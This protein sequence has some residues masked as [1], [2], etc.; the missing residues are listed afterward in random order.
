MDGRGNTNH[1]QV[2]SDAVLRKIGRNVVLFQQIEGLLKFLV[3]NHKVDG[4]T[5]TLEERRQHR[6]EKAH[7]QT[8]CFSFQTTRPPGSVCSPVKRKY[9]T[10]EETSRH[11]RFSY[12]R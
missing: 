6:V 9:R 2:S 11:P 3:A 7:K 10:R 5:S 8:K 4:S 1:D 12:P